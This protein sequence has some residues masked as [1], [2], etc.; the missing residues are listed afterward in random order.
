MQVQPMA[1]G[2]SRGHANLLYTG[3][4]NWCQWKWVILFQPAKS[5]STEMFACRVLMGPWKSHGRIQRQD[6]LDLKV[7]L[8][9]LYMGYF[10]HLHVRACSVELWMLEGALNLWRNII[11]ISCLM[12]ACMHRTELEWSLKS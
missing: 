2:L 7:L 12:H 11:D 9:G 1:V 10:K 3:F 6:F 5:S 8:R 4:C